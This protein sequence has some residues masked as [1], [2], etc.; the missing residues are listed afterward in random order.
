MGPSNGVEADPGPPEE[1]DEED[2]GSRGPEGGPLEGTGLEWSEPPRGDW[3]PE[4][5]TIIHLAIC[6]H[7]RQN[8][9]ARC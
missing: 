9:A 5:D 8:D 3:Y 2:E 6:F 4:R 1:E 7:V